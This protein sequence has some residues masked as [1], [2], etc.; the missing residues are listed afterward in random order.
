METTAK[1]IH[2]VAMVV[3]ADCHV[4]GKDINPDQ[5]PLILYNIP[6]ERNARVCDFSVNG[7]GYGLMVGVIDEDDN[8]YYLFDR[9]D[10]YADSNFED[11]EDFYMSGG[12]RLVVW[13][14]K[15]EDLKVLASFIIYDQSERIELIRLSTTAIASKVSLTIPGGYYTEPMV[16]NVFFGLYGKEYKELDNNN[17]DFKV[18]KTVDDIEIECNDLSMQSSPGQATFF[19][20]FKSCFKGGD[21]INLYMNNNTKGSMCSAYCALHLR[22]CD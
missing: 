3:P 5:T 11:F 14:S 19:M 13:G 20:F 2:T 12:D 22:E 21:T 6:Q 8:L 9:T 18:S 4:Y 15:T 7:P 17:V 16:T 10:T 1:Q